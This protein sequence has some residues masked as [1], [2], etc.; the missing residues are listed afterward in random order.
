MDLFLLSISHK[1]VAEANFALHETHCKRFLCLC[2][3]CEETVP[4]ELL[5]QHREEQHTGTH[6]QMHAH[7]HEQTETLLKTVYRWNAQSATKR[8]NAVTWWTTRFVLNIKYKKQFAKALKIYLVKRLSQSD[9]C[10]ERLQTCLFCKLLLPWKELGQHQH[11]CGSRTELCGDC[12]CYVT[13]RDQPVHWTTCPATSAPS[14]TN[15]NPSSDTSKRMQPERLWFKLQTWYCFSSY[16]L[17]STAKSRVRRDRCKA[18]I[19][20]EGIEKRKVCLKDCREIRA[21]LKGLAACL[22]WEVCLF[23]LRFSEI[24][25]AQPPSVSQT[26]W[27]VFHLTCLMIWRKQHWRTLERLHLS[28]PSR[29]LSLLLAA[30]TRQRPSQTESVME[31]TTSAPAPTVTWPCPSPRCSGIR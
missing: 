15:S 31:G 27:G 29:K 25:R 2:P 23:S 4:R 24:F 28:F 11:I 16:S 7:T 3:D 22:Q 30:A 6:A 13:L 5:D 26:S 1:M 12:R 14:Q 9:H 18:S 17:F 20:A 21:K 19:P 10:A 8:W